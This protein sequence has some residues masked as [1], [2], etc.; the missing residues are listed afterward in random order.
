MANAQ[1]ASDIIRSLSFDLPASKVLEI[2]R[3][4]GLTC[5]ANLV[6]NTRARA[7]VKQASG[8]ATPARNKKIVVGARGIAAAGADGVLEVN[9]MRMIIQVGTSET[10]KLIERIETEMCP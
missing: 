9:L 2:V 8:E 7:R 10:R 4:H 5:H 1:T 3:S 6:Y